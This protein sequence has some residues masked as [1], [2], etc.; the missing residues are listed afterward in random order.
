MHKVISYLSTKSVWESLVRWGIHSYF[1]DF[2]DIPDEYYD[3]IK[4]Y[5]Y[6]LNT[7]YN[8]IY[9]DIYL[10]YYEFLNDIKW[11]HTKK[12]FALK[13]KDHKYQKFLFSIYTNKP[14][15]ILIW[16]KIKPE[17]EKLNSILS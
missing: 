13:V 4:S 14:I 17:Y 11:N 2:K 3:I 12:E 6:Y 16:N 8:I 7:K 9:H 10:V 1:N 5:A 15:N